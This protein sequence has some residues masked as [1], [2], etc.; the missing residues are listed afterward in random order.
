MAH[1]DIEKKEHEYDMGC[2][3]SN[4]Y[5]RFWMQIRCARPIDAKA[6]KIF[7]F[8]GKPPEIRVRVDNN[9]QVC[10]RALTKS[11]ADRTVRSIR[12]TLSWFH[13]PAH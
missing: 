8:L 3:N 9:M 11:K 1:P 7:F 5:Q 6:V 2:W 13:R 4:P 10:V 12:S